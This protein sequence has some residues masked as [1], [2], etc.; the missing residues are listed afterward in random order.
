VW[1]VVAGGEGVPAETR[2]T[3]LLPLFRATIEL[4]E[5]NPGATRL[6]LAIRKGADEVLGT[7]ILA[8][9]SK[10]GPDW[11]ARFK[12]GLVTATLGLGVW[13]AWQLN[14]IGA[15]YDQHVYAA[16]GAG[17]I[18]VERLCVKA[19]VRGQGIASGMLLQA[20]DKVSQGKPTTFSLATQEASTERIYR[21]LGFT[22]VAMDR[23]PAYNKIPNWFMRRGTAP[24]AHSGGPDQARPQPPSAGT[25]AIQ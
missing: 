17:S 12:S 7:C 11:S 15:W 2:T 24:M 18:A 3:R 10:T 25:C 16:G 22:T 1:V 5:L 19:S 9:L 8:D 4:C 13:Q 14:Q 6:F 21:K 20:I 23:Y